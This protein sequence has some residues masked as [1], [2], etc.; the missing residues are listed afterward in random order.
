MARYSI[1]RLA[2]KQVIT[3][4]GLP[5]GELVD[6]VVDEITGKALRLACRPSKDELVQELIRTLPHDK[7]GN[8]LIPFTTVKHVRDYIVLDEKLV[9]IYSMRSRMKVRRS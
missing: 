2:R 7:G 8:V 1:G 9:R 5:I 3:D 4:R 6:M